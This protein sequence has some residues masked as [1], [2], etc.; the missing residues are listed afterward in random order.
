MTPLLAV[1]ARGGD[2][3]INM[4]EDVLAKEAYLSIKEILERNGITNHNKKLFSLMC[5]A[6]QAGAKNMLERLMRKEHESTDP[7]NIEF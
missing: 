4:K 2:E 6:Y 3:R 1:K 7:D 5:R